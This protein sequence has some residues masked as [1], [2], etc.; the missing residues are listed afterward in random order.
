M[1]SRLVGSLEY[2]LINGLLYIKCI[3]AS[4]LCSHNVSILIKTLDKCMSACQDLDYTE[5]FVGR[6]LQI[7]L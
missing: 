1:E 5:C 3:I 7:D 4:L 2:L 6:D